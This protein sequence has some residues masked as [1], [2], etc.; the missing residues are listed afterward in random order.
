LQLIAVVA[1]TSVANLIGSLVAY[2]VTR[3]YGEAFVLGP[4]RR[5]GLHAGHLK[6]AHRVFDR[7]GLVAVFAGRLL[8]IVRTY[9][10]FPAG[11]SR[12]TP[13]R[14]SVLTLAGSIPWNF[15]LA[16]AGFKLGQNH[17]QVGKALGPF[18]IPIV[19]IVVVLL[20][21]AYYLG[22][23]ISQDAEATGSATAAR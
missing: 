19:V 1:V 15:A 16:F 12:I 7:W 6:L 18:T 22:Q 5:L 17:E 9:I 23:R 14:F 13:G 20:G 11:V 21:V 8:P 3:R 10:S 4:G 2:L